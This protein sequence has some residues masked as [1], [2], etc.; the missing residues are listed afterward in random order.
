MVVVALRPTTRAS[1]WALSTNAHVLGSGAPTAEA[2]AAAP[3]RAAA[4]PPPPPKKL[5]IDLD[6]G[7]PFDLPAFSL[8]A[9]GGMVPEVVG[10]IPVRILLEGFAHAVQIDGR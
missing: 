7:L 3:P 4:P 8:P 6:E 1:P 9:L 5:V 10:P 2:A